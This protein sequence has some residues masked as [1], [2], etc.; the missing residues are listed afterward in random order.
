MRIIQYLTSLFLLC[1]LP[2]AA[3]T[4]DLPLPVQSALNHRKLS[5]DSLSMYVQDLDSGETVLQWQD[6]VP[7]NP[8]STIKLLTT[9]VALDVLGPTYRWN[10]DIYAL[11]EVENGILSGDLLIEGHGD[12]FLV[13]ERVWQLL[14]G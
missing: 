11:G 5:N 12:P 14:R 2:Q 7:R 9:L 6:D 13:T 4:S 10:T 3:L 1:F 8:G